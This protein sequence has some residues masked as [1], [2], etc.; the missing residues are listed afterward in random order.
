MERI[1][2]KLPGILLGVGD[3]GSGPE[4]ERRC[5]RYWRIGEAGRVYWVKRRRRKPLPSMSTSRSFRAGLF[6]GSTSG[7]V[8]AGCQS[9]H[10]RSHYL[11]A[12]HFFVLPRRVKGM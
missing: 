1:L 9:H 4:G 3:E 2:D 7:S 12:L 6:G 11:T 8:G 5:W 10:N